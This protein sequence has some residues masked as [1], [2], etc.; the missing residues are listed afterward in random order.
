MGTFGSRTTPTMAPQLRRVAAAARETLSNRRRKMEHR[1]EHPRRGRCA[2]VKRS[3]L[4]DVRPAYGELRTAKRSRKTLDEDPVTPA[5][6]WTVAGKSAPEVDGRDVR[7]R[8]RTV[9][10]AICA[11]PGMMYG[12][13]LR[14]PSF[15]AT[16]A[17]CD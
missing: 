1:P 6:Q 15:G 17:S 16:L 14:P 7:H 12:K 4:Q 3:L 5:S 8:T 2:K 9:H 10:I 11:R 13:V